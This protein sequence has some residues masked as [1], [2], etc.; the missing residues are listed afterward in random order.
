LA[1]APDRNELLVA[2][3][4]PDGTNVV[5]LDFDEKVLGRFVLPPTDEVFTLTYDARSRVL[6]V[7]DGTDRLEVSGSDLIEDRP[8]VV[9]VD[10][11]ATDVDD[12][13]A[14]AFDEVTGEWLV[15]DGASN[16]VVRSTDSIEHFYPAAELESRTLLGVDSEAL[17]GPAALNSTDGLL[18][19]LAKDGQS[20]LA[21]D[22]SGLIRGTVDVSSITIGNPTAMTFAPSSDPTDDPT[23]MN[24]F[25]ADAG[26][27]GS[28]GG[29]LEL[30]LSTV[31]APL[32]TA[33]VDTATLVRVTDTSSWSPASPD[34]SGV[35]YLPGSGVLMVVDSEVDETTGAGYHDVNLWTTSW[36]GVV[37]ATG[38]TWTSSGDP[39]YP[40]YSKEPTGVGYDL[41]AGPGT[42]R[43]FISD[44]SA[45]GVHVV[46]RGQDGS[47]GTADD[48]LAF[49]DTGTVDVED[50]ELVG[51]ILYQ[52]DGVSSEIYRIDPVD[53]IFGNADD[54]M[55][56]FDIGYLGPADWE[57]LA[58]DPIRGTLYAG[59]RATGQIFE[60]TTSGSLVRTIDVDVPELDNISGL[61]TA[62]D[63]AGEL[64]FF[65]VDR[66]V[67]NGNNPNENDGR[68]FEVQ[69]GDPA[70]PSNLPP[71]VNA[72]P[73][74]LTNADTNVTLQGVVV[75]DG[76]PAGATVTQLW[77]IDPASPNSD[78]TFSD[79]T[80]TSSEATFGT[81]GTYILVLTANDTDLSG[82]DSVTVTVDP[83][84]TVSRSFAIASGF[85]DAEQLLPNGSGKL[86]SSDLDL[87]FDGTTANTAGLR[88]VG[89]DVPHGATILSASLQFRA[90]ETDSA[91][92]VLAIAAEAIG[93]APPFSSS[94]GDISNRTVGTQQVGWA[95]PAWSKGVA[96]P[97]QASPDIAAVIQEVVNR[98]DWATNNA[99]ALVITGTGYRKADSIEGGYA[100]QLEIKYTSDNDLQI[101]RRFRWLLRM[102]LGRNLV[103]M[104]AST[105]FLELDR[106][107]RC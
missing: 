105:S 96:G 3:S 97:D 59:A 11:S 75:D 47:F 23:Q 39:S 13:T 88:F 95:V 78:V 99:L 16:E 58:S 27:A 25:L 41:G 17:A 21:V 43:L 28:P 6:T 33:V 51:G 19:A 69:V 20:L 65:I 10:V 82:S 68:M 73:D 63:T 46:E 50:P 53:G 66:G 14:A 54:V 62:L 60:I 71:V 107:M 90:D 106:L 26:D 86:S 8:P 56:S 98:A 52:L 70:P 40:A 92:A 37:V 5:R 48:V 31:Q 87:G 83:A 104:M 84:G 93:D 76:L 57:G 35:A 29:V 77:T 81:A 18:Y 102:L 42:D 44:D 80:L 24:L 103:P 7:M 34:P 22:E 67:D 94:S 9:R 91:A 2:A 4:G 89:V 1:F 85:D 45:S 100:T 36:A 72:G 55:T 64:S 15:L 30:S 101:C 74:F 32:A 12:P 61:T 38:T 49:V 79:P